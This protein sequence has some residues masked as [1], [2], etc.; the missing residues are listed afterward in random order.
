METKPKRA[1]LIKVGDIVV[2]NGKSYRIKEIRRGTKAH[3][4]GMH[5]N[6]RLIADGYSFDF[7]SQ[8]ESTLLMV[9]VGRGLKIK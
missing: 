3:A 8:G 7:F 9:K 6:L 4:N 2:E 1:S 5:F